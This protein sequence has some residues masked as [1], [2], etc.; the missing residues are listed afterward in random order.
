M[1]LEFEI[2][3]EDY[4]VFKTKTT[5]FNFYTEHIIF[6]SCEWDFWVSLHKLIG[7]I[8][9]AE[10]YGTEPLLATFHKTRGEKIG[11]FDQSFLGV[12]P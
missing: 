12:P 4:A 7:R 3:A 9:G 10:L 2:I 11:L 8:V 1:P 5:T 6:R